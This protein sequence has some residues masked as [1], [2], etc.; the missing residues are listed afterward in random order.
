M[1]NPKSDALIAN[2]GGQWLYLRTLANTK[3]DPDIFAGF[4]ENLRQSFQRETELFLSSIFREDRSVL[5]LLDANYTFV[6]QRL[7]EHYKIPNVYGSHFRRV[8]L[9]DGNRGGLLGQG[10]ILTVT[11]TRNRASWFSAASGSSRTCSVRLRLPRLPTCR[12]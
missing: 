8:T 6:N 2:F 4:D 12:N 9:P 10:S 5:E 3:P 1:A 11:S 7:A